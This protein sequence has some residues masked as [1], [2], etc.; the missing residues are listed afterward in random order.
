MCWVV[1]GGGAGMFAAIAAARNGAKV[2]LTD[3]NLFGA[4]PRAENA[5]GVHLGLGA[6]SEGL[7]FSISDRQRSNSARITTVTMGPLEPAGFLAT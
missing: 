5:N 4:A 3:N 7:T 6:T 1:V 2:L